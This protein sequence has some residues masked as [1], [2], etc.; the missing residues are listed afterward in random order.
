MIKTVTVNCPTGCGAEITAEID[1]AED[2]S[3]VFCGKCNTKVRVLLD[4]APVAFSQYLDSKAEAILAAL[5]IPSPRK[6]GPDIKKVSKPGEQ[7]R[8]TINF[9]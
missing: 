3:D 6:T 9:T 7:N 8:L 5:D 1:S 2:Y 4:K